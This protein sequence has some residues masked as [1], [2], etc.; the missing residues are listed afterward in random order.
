MKKR[1][2]DFYKVN[3]FFILI[4]ILV[5][6]TASDSFMIEPYGRLKMV[7]LF[8]SVLVMGVLTSVG[9][10]IGDLNSENDDTSWVEKMLKLGVISSCLILLNEI[11][12]LCLVEKIAYVIPTIIIGGWF[13]FSILKSLNTHKHYE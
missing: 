13:T 4:M 7:S 2:K 9:K 3:V 11:T 10:S 8:F 12:Y 1:K 5:I 6:G